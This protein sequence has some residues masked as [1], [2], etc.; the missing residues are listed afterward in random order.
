LR[1]IVIAEQFPWT[2]DDTK[3]GKPAFPVVSR[4]IGRSAKIKWFAARLLRAA[5]EYLGKRLSIE[6]DV[7]GCLNSSSFQN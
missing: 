6:L 1:A 4:A 7:V 5:Q 2:V 3:V